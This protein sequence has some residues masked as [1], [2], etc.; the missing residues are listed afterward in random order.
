MTVILTAVIYCLSILPFT[1]YLIAGPHL[2]E[3]PPGMFHLHFYRC[4][5]S[6]L[7]LSVV[8]NFYIYLLTITSFRQF[9]FYMFSRV[10]RG[11]T[12]RRADSDSYIYK[13]E[14]P[15]GSPYMNN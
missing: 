8:S 3:D 11:V 4:A 13:Y 14:L 15:P 1:L 2:T 6:I 12:M 5:W 10:A 9:I 7:M